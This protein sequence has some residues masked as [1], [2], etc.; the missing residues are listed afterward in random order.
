MAFW[1][2]CL[3]LFGLAQIVGQPQIL[4]SVSPY[5]SRRTLKPSSKGGMPLWMDR[6]FIALSKN[7]TDATEYFHIPTGRVVEIGTQVVL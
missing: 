6:V 1:F 5:L 2:I 4:L 7:A 3:G